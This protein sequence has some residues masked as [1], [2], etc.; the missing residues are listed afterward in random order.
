MTKKIDKDNTM[1]IENI[2][3]VSRNLLKFDGDPRDWGRFKDVFEIS[4]KRSRFSEKEN[5]LRFFER[6]KGESLESV[7]TLFISNRKTNIQSL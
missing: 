3:Y 1:L 6:L 7:R 2:N 4:S 5:F